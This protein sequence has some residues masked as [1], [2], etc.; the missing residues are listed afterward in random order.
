MLRWTI[1]IL[2]NRGDFTNNEVYWPRT[3]VIYL[4]SVSNTYIKVYIVIMILVGLGGLG[5][6]SSPPDTRFAGSN[7]T[8]VGGFFQDVKIMSTSPP[9]GT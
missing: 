8:E 3:P 6:T 9:G 2:E 1:A 5:I 7:P 4:S